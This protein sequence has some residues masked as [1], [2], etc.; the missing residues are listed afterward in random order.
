[1]VG[2]VRTP[3]GRVRLS[4]ERSKLRKEVVQSMSDSVSTGEWE[5]NNLSNLH[6]GQKLGTPVQKVR[7]NKT[8]VRRKIKRTK[9]SVPTMS[10]ATFFRQEHMRRSL[11][12]KRLVQEHSVQRLQHGGEQV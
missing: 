9:R 2:R 3:I 10:R 8:R 4:D 1:M 6:T 5:T 7:N 11:S 12:R